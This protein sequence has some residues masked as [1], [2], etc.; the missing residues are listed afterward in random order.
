MADVASSKE[1]PIEE[2][3]ATLE[4]ISSSNHAPVEPKSEGPIFEE[5]AATP[6]TPIAP[7]AAPDGGWKAWSAVLGGFLCQFASFGFLNV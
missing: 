3:K 2:E 5:P 7:F 4:R 1:I 6:A